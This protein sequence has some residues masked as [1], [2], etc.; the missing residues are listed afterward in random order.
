MGFMAHVFTAVHA[1]NQLKSAQKYV[2]DLHDIQI[3]SN[4]THD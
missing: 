1:F 2:L 3:V 4:R